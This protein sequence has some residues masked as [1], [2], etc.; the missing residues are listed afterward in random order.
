[1]VAV[2][3]L[4]A[5]GVTAPLA[6]EKKVENGI[7]SERGRGNIATRTDIAHALTLTDVKGRGVAFEHHSYFHHVDKN[8][9]VI[10]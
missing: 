9:G 4:I 2:R 7:E 8:R 10:N 1:M 3:L 6:P 5:L